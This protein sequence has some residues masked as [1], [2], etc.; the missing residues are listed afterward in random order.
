MVLDALLAQPEPAPNIPL[1]NS[2]AALMAASL[3]SERL[4]PPNRPSSEPAVV[5]YHEVEVKRPDNTPPHIV[6]HEVVP[7]FPDLNAKKAGYA[8]PAGVSFR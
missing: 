1:P 5:R 8:V 3:E 7:K 4:H 6:Y 2:R